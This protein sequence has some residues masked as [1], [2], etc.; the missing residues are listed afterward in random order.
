L[1]SDSIVSLLKS[2]QSAPTQQASLDVGAALAKVAAEKA[3]R[4]ARSVH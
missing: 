1:T 2:T 3:G 4:L